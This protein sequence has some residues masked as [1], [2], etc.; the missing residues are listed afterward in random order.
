MVR[1]MTPYYEADGVTLFHG[2][3]RDVDAW[4]DADALIT[5][6]PYGIAYRSGR[7]N[8]KGS[9][10]VIESD[11]DT[12]ARDAALD[13]WAAFGGAQAAVFGSWKIPRPAGTHTVLVWSKNTSGMGDLAQPFGPSHEEIYLLGRWSKPDGFK[14]R[15]SV[16]ATTEHPQ[17]TA[18]LVAHPTPKPVGLMEVLVSATPD[19]ASI[20][21]PF[22]GGGATLLAAR[23]LGRKAIGVEIDERY[24]EVIANRLSQM[25]LG[26]A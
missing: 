20:A 9:V 2:D 3:C 24:C 1:P 5:D 4:L 13:M 23:N 17:R 7:P 25:C 22:A 26:F 6:P 11:T 12:D 21:D 10:R 18:E 16:I 19:G 14:R 8:P 15:G